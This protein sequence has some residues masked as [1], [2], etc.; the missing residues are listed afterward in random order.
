MCSLELNIGH[1][2][3]LS[4]ALLEVRQ[5]KHKLITR[6]REIQATP[7]HPGCFVSATTET[8]RRNPANA[9]VI[10]SLIQHITHPLDVGSSQHLSWGFC[11]SAT[12]E[13]ES[14]HSETNK[15]DD[16][17]FESERRN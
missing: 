11:E 17:C 5:G 14:R 1:P 13:A 8:C 10:G 9:G 12:K 6:P 4:A 7:L 2:W 3:R 16:I 15:G